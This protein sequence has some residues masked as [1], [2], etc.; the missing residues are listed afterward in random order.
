MGEVFG[1]KVSAKRVDIRRNQCKLVYTP[2]GSPPQGRKE[3]EPPVNITQTK[4]DLAAKYDVDVNKIVLV[5]QWHSE[6]LAEDPSCGMY[7]EPGSYTLDFI[8]IAGEKNTDHYG[9]DQFSGWGIDQ[10]IESWKSD[11]PTDGWLL[12]KRVSQVKMGRETVECEHDVLTCYECDHSSQIDWDA[13][14]QE[15]CQKA[16]ITKAD[17]EQILTWYYD[18]SY[19]LDHS[20]REK[21]ESVRG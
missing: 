3:R 13:I 18:D 11:N 1:E 16:G 10:D 2:K 20:L 21:L 9:S 4:R 15:A 17:I 19:E 8:L 12:L 6:C 5:G 14:Q 7:W